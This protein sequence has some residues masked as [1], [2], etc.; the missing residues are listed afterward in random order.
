ME[1][2]YFLSV[3]EPVLAG[4]HIFKAHLRI[5][6]SH[7]YI[8]KIKREVCIKDFSNIF[9]NNMDSSSIFF[10]SIDINFLSVLKIKLTMK[11]WKGYTY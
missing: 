10:P 5:Q 4:Y 1:D 8:F 2:F 9:V 3:V 6:I 11:A 7:I